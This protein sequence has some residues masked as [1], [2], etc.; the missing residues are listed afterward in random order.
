MKQQP[1][2]ISGYVHNGLLSNTR[3]ELLLCL[4]QTRALRGE[5]EYSKPE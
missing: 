2:E 1:L 3:L 4:H 5:G